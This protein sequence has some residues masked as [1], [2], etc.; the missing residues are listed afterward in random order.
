MFFEVP[1]TEFSWLTLNPQIKFSTQT[2]ETTIK[3]CDT[4]ALFY[5][6]HFSGSRR[7]EH[8]IKVLPFLCAFS[9][10][11]T[12]F[13]S[14]LPSPCSSPQASGP[15]LCTPVQLLCWALSPTVPIG[16]PPMKHPLVFIRSWLEFTSLGLQ[17]PP[18][19]F[20]ISCASFLLS[21]SPPFF[22]SALS[23]L[24]HTR[25]FVFILL[26][27]FSILQGQLHDSHGFCP[28]SLKQSQVSSRH[29][30]VWRYTG[31]CSC[32]P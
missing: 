20:S 4:A 19:H 7:S 27:A 30:N 11:V 5:S 16:V 29:T 12:S 21:I 15:S 1:L 17:W 2:P 31:H 6:K 23:S 32:S 26:S 18:Q 14:P 10:P 22:F 3:S 9:N 28:P 24:Q 13:L 8:K 25:Q